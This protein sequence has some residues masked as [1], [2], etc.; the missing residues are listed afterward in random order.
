MIHLSATATATANG[1]NRMAL[2]QKH[3]LCPSI[4][5]FIFALLIPL[6][7]LLFFFLSFTHSPPSPS[8]LSHFK[9]PHSL[10]F[11]RLSALFAIP[12]LSLFWQSFFIFHSPLS[13]HTQPYLSLCLSG[14]TRKCAPAQK[15][16]IIAQLSHN[17]SSRHFH[18]YIN[19]HSRQLNILSTQL[20]IPSTG[21]K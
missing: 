21:K 20:R 19:I 18:I 6:S 8:P 12:C 13:L 15:I 11:L 17:A 5:P 16:R 14:I 4:S 2:P 9:S 7:F 10:L 1:Y 3:F